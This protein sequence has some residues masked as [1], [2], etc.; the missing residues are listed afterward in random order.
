M[1]EVKADGNILNSSK[2][3][4]IIDDTLNLIIPCDNQVDK[5]NILSKFNLVF[6]KNEIQKFKMFKIK[7]HLNG[8]FLVFQ[9]NL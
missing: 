9:I 4:E 1:T 2:Y 6:K 5:D 7:H 8:Y 3:P